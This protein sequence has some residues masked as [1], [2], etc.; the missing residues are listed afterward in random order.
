[1]RPSMHA[2]QSMETD[3]PI[4]P[5]KRPSTMPYI[6]GCVCLAVA[7]LGAL[8]AYRGY[9]TNMDNQINSVSEVII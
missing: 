9:T 7:A 2:R 1:M 6:V 3:L 5:A 4:A 8:L